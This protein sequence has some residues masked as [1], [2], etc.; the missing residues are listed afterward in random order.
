MSVMRESYRSLQNTSPTH[1][2][3]SRTSYM[4]MWLNCDYQN[5]VLEIHLKLSLSLRLIINLNLTL[6]LGLE[7]ETKAFV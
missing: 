6:R 3:A 7:R 4:V 5:M 2:M 1:Q